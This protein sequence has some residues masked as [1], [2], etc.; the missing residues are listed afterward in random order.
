LLI[1]SSYITS[2]VKVSRFLIIIPYSSVEE[3]IIGVKKASAVIYPAGA[4]HLSN[5]YITDRDYSIILIADA[6]VPIHVEVASRQ[7]HDKMQS[8]ESIH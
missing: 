1:P 4:P 7:S 3:L 6:Y 5:L 8:S 2:E